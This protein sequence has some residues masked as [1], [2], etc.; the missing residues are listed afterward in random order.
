MGVYCQIGLKHLRKKEY[1]D[2]M[3]SFRKGVKFC[4]PDCMVALGYMY[5]HGLNCENNAP[6]YHMASYMYE[7]AEKRDSTLAAVNLGSI[8]YHGYGV[9]KDYGRAAEQFREAIENYTAKEPE[10]YKLYAMVNLGIC[11]LLGRGVPRNH[12]EAHRLF[13]LAHKGGVLEGTAYLGKMKQKGWYLLRDLVG[14]KKLFE[15]CVE[16]E[17]PM[18]YTCLGVV[19]FKGYGVD[20]DL[21]KTEELFLKAVEL[22][23]IRAYVMLGKL[24][25]YYKPNFD[26]AFNMLKTAADKG[27]GKAAIYLSDMLRLGMGRPADVMKAVQILQRVVNSGHDN[28]IEYAN[29]K[30]NMILEEEVGNPD[31]D[32]ID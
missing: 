23:D 7:N 19:Y 24:Y 6:R 18:G 22:G 1:M 14:A 13:D 17:L 3:E 27:S 26:K 28:E 8:Y 11:Y 21:D 4:D 25:A 16:K 20:V 12:A 5:Q 10:T 30:I 31:W 32:N 29:A 2:A 15:H 9:A